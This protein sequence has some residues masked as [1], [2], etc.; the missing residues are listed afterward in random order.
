MPGSRN[1][2]SQYPHITHLADPQG[3]YRM[4]QAY[5]QWMAIKNYSERTIE[6]REFFLLWFLE[7]CGQ[8]GLI[9]PSE[10]TKPILER[11]QRTLFHYRKR[12]G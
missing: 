11:Y 10:I 5:L 4:V 1:D 3:M 8:R 9:R 12:N 2:V 6:G 7:W